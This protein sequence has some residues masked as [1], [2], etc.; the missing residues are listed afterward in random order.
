MRNSKL[1]NIE[2]LKEKAKKLDNLYRN[3]KASSSQIAELFGLLDDICD[4]EDNTP[5]RKKS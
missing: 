2:A 3:N 5:P 4:F 1:N